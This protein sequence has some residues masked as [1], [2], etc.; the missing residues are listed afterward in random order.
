MNQL[1]LPDMDSFPQIVNVASVKHRSPFRYPGGKTWLV[2][3][4]FAWLRSR[5]LPVRNFI[6]PFAGGAIVGLSV[7]FEQL[8]EHVTLVELDEQ[9]A[10]VW[11]AI[12]TS[13][14]GESLAEKILN[15][16]LTSDVADQLLSKSELPL[17]ERALQTIVRN[18]INRGGI[19]AHGAGRLK[20]G[21]NGRG[22]RSRWYPET[23]ATRIRNLSQ[24]RDR[25]SFIH[26]DGLQTIVDNSSLSDVVFFVDPPYTAS[27][28]KPGKRLYDCADLN[29]VRLFELLAR[30]SGEFLMTYDNVEEV[31]LL[32]QA[33][34]FDYLA[35]PM[36]NAHH[37]KLNELLIGR[38]L[39][40]ARS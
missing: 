36:K 3:K 12:I 26:G 13:G 2:P 15:L 9:V 25:L 40:W 6:E 16:E 27:D 8:A 34:N 23:L 14:D 35:I 7:A 29:H 21:E 37:A 33:F 31:K 17:C 1:S 28:K 22:I 32:A 39:D 18:R 4:V 10:A 11:E 19:M 30:S 20:D 5:N 24:I 38:N